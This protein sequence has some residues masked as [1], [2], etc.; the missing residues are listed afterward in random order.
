MGVPS[1]TFTFAASESRIIIEDAYRRAGIIPSVLTQEQITS[2]QISAN[3]IL[4]SW[5][6]RGLNLYTVK[7]EM[8]QLVP[9]Q[10]TYLLPAT[11]STV[12]EVTLRSSQRNLGGTAFSS[13]GIAGNSFNGVPGSACVQNAPNGF[14]GYQWGNGNQ[15][16]IQLVGVQSNVNQN[17]SLV[18][19]YSNDGMTY[20]SVGEPPAQLF[21]AG[22]INWFVI[23]APKFGSWFQIRET[24]GATLNMQQLYFN[25]S[26]YDYILTAASRAEYMAYPNKNLVGRPALYYFDRQTDP[27]ITL[28]P[29]P[30]AQY[31]NLYYTRV[32]EIQDVGTLQNNI[33]VPSRFYSALTWQLA[34]S[35]ASKIPNFDLNKLN[36]LYAYAKEEFMLASEEDTERVP[37]RIFP[38]I[39]GYLQQ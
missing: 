3:L 29:T 8:L 2:A 1:G 30:S 20:Q 5:L 33:A 36:L 4:S 31:N 18:F 39:N 6:N 28:W 21:L 14:I 34:H 23:L 25:T 17:Y 9:M 32:E 26:L 12:L 15:Y 37:L 19:E 11:T 27:S 38:D 10:N 22:Q 13:S 16:N 24:A 7:Q 35:I